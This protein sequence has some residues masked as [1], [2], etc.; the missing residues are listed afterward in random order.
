MRTDPQIAS[1]FESCALP[2]WTANEQLR[3]FAAGFLQQIEIESGDLVNNPVA[4][5]YLLELTSGVRQLMSTTGASIDF[6]LPTCRAPS[7]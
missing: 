4:M 7:R 1:R 3:S 6:Q 5:D 2:S